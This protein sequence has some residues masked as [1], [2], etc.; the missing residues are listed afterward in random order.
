LGLVVAISPT[1]ITVVILMLL[2]GRRT[3]VSVVFAAAY[4]FGIVLDTVLLLALGGAAGLA[5]QSTSS[6][7]VA[8][9]QLVVG[10]LLVLLG[11]D[12]WSKRPKA[13]E[14]TKLPRWM[15]A[16]EDFTVVKAAGVSLF[17]SALRPK[18]VLMFAAASVAIG[19]GHLGVV[20][21][22]IAVALFAIIGASTVVALVIAA[23]LRREKI[24]PWLTELRFWLETNTKA[25]MSIVLVLV[26]V[27]EVGKGF[28][29][30]F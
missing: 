6:G 26:G 7:G 29:G 17:L 28:G 12:E 3:S 2:S 30:I 13:G 9:L 14:T 19:T 20:D 18:N 24:K 10:V 8:W 22:T 11:L 15:A 5:T 16:M 27:V 4:L 1:T 23:I 25:M 21:A